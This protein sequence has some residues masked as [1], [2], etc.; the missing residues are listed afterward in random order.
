MTIIA[1][2]FLIFSFFVT[3][4]QIESTYLF[5]MMGQE[6]S[7][8]AM[9]CGLLYYSMSEKQNNDKLIF[10]FMIS[11][12]LLG[13]KSKMFAE[14]F[15][16]L[17]I[18]FFLQKKL[19][20]FSFKTLLVFFTLLVGAI[21]VAWVKFDQYYVTGMSDEGLVRPMMYKTSLFVLR[22]YFP[23]GS[24]FGTFATETSRVFYSTLYA[25]YQL[26]G[27]WGLEKGDASFAADTYY[28]SLAQFGVVGVG[29]FVAFWRKRFLEIEKESIERYK[30][31]LFVMM[32]LLGDAIADSTY[33]SN[34]GIMMWIILGLL[35]SGSIKNNDEA[36]ANK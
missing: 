29:L 19:R 23:F 3:G 9:S 25:K 22:D 26:W 4:A 14:V 15:V 33:V 8:T 18:L 36:Y 28:P 20:L 10:A 24:G 34:R 30:L 11:V 2:I 1:T 16:I 31:G 5:G 6:L 12:G 32:A 7:T 13:G 35:I 27:I 21:F 17:F